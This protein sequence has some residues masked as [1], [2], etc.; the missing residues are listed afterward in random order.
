[1]GALEK[2]NESFGGLD[3]VAEQTTLATKEV[4]KVAEST[5]K[6]VESAGKAAERGSKGVHIF[7]AS[8]LRIVKY[9]ILRSVIRSITS[10]FQEGLQN[11]YHF[12]QTIDGNLAK[13]LDTL[14]TK[15]LTMKNQLG[16]AFGS[17]ITTL[18]PVI[19]KIIEFVTRA[20]EAITRLFA[21]LG[22]QGG[23]KKAVDASKQWAENTKAGAGAAKEMRRQLM[24]FDVINRLDAPSNGGGGGGGSV[25]TDYSKMFEW[26]DLTDVAI[27]PI[28]IASNIVDKVRDALNKASDWIASYDWNGLGGKVYDTLRRIFTEIDWGGLAGAISRFLGNA[29]G[30]AVSYLTGF[31][32][33]LF[34]DVKD[35]FK[36]KTEEMGGNVILGFLKGILDAVIGIGTWI[37]DH[38]IKP[39][40]TG[41]LEGLGIKDAS[42]VTMEEI[43]A[44]I[45]KGLQD[46][47]EKSWEQLKKVVSDLFDIVKD[48]WDGLVE[49]FFSP[50][51]NWLDRIFAPRSASFRVDTWT[52]QWIN[53][54]GIPGVFAEGGYPNEDG[55]F[56]ANHN[57]LVGKFSNGRTAVANNE[58]IVEGIKRGVFEAMA[59][60]LSGNSGTQ[61]VNVYLDGKQITN[62]VTRNQRQMSRATGVAYG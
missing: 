42:S 60:A 9:R 8:L 22:G 21:I 16:A 6:A 50:I 4:G 13:A 30:A 23:Y 41:F 18:E 53:P 2:I 35:Y 55:L 20:A 33:S 28:A 45:V 52:N 7:G 36:Q 43:G 3:K 26:V 12:S 24:G 14:S 48:I 44:A 19:Q 40:V 47:I 5:G 61:N 54:M 1:M 62:A 10:A 29:I 46:G 57:E 56:L 49:S 27:D 58:Q 38:V 25:S 17:L 51:S 15:S 31:A 34:R 39:F 11:A 32:S 37:Y 59:A